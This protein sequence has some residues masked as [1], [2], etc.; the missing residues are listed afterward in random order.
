M[1][2][3]WDKVTPTRRKELLMDY[4]Q[5]LPI[6]AMTGDGLERLTQELAKHLL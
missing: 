3:K 4:P 5:A 1:L 6:S 2:N